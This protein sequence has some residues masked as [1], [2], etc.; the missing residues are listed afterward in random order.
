MY[1]PNITQTYIVKNKL[2]TE[3]DKLKNTPSHL[4]PR[5]HKNM[6][7]VPSEYELF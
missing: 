1:L 4:S 6:D 2:L 5:E 7:L 3:R